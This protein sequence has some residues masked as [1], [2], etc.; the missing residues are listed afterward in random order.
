MRVV[1]IVFGI[2]VAI[3]VLKSH[4][5]ERFTTVSIRRPAWFASFRECCG[6]LVGP[7]T[8]LTAGHCSIKP[9]DPVVL[10]SETQEREVTGTDVVGEDLV[11]VRVSGP[12][13]A[14][15]LAST[16]N[17]PKAGDIVT[18]YN[19][20]SNH[21]ARQYEMTD[22]ETMKGLARPEMLGKGDSGAAVLDSRGNLVGL[23][24]GMVDKEGIKIVRVLE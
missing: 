18:A 4:R 23:V 9:G 17:Q 2:V 10:E 22:S 20:S 24:R 16:G 1:W 11:R 7:N 12:K 21:P 14:E 8:V 5:K 13:S 6:V 3:V 19:G 15:Y